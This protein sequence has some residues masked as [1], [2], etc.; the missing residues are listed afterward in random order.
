MAY[1]EYFY[2]AHS[3]YAYLGSKA[4]QNIA[5]AAGREIRH[6]PYDRVVEL[7]VGCRISEPDRNI[8]APTTSVEKWNGAE[9]RRY[10]DSG[11]KASQ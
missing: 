3:A 11:P 4:L 1:I 9:E 10:H 5:A 6:R 2:A 8:I 7:P